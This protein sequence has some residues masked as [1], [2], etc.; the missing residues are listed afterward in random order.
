MCTLR[1]FV[2]PS[3]CQFQDSL[4]SY[5]RGDEN[6]F[7]KKKPPKLSTI[8]TALLVHGNIVACCSSERASFAGSTVTME[9]R[10]LP[11]LIF[12]N[13]VHFEASHVEFHFHELTS[14]QKSTPKNVTNAL[15]SY[16][17]QS[18]RALFFRTCTCKFAGSTSHGG[19]TTSS[20]KSRK[21][22]AF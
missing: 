19:A 4:K 15:I 10:R 20:G 17:W 3:V 14:N 9:A 7:K 12:E 18:C 5:S 2:S 1:F 13:S 11:V 21:F 6:T 16:A 22:R 8:P